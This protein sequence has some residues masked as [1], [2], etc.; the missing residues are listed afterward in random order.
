[1]HSDLAP[2][3]PLLAPKSPNYDPPKLD[4]SPEW[5]TSYIDDGYLPPVR[6]SGLS[7]ALSA[8]CVPVSI[9]HLN[10][11]PAAPAALLPL[12]PLRPLLPLL[13]LL[14]LLPLLPLLSLLPL[15]LL[16]PLLPRALPPAQSVAEAHSVP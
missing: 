16:L 10:D 8:K 11:D 3:S 6:A 15:L 13:L 14:P 1:M 9:P 4:L 12:L 5:Q 7:C 2:G